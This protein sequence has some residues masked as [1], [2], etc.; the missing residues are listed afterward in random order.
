[1]GIAFLYWRVSAAWICLFHG[2]VGVSDLDDVFMRAA[3]LQFLIQPA[4]PKDH[5]M[6]QCKECEI[7]VAGKAI[8]KE[9]LAYEILV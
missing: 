2:L 8:S 5:L 1:M 4:Y 6:L 3:G 9:C 7:Q